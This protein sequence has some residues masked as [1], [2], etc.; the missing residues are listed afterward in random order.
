MPKNDEIWILSKLQV[1][2]QP[3][4]N[5]NITNIQKQDD[6]IIERSLEQNTKVLQNTIYNNTQQNNT[7]SQDT[8]SLKNYSYSLT[9]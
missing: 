2:P 5:R 7:F 4:K 1:K 9:N 6:Y 3:F 8:V